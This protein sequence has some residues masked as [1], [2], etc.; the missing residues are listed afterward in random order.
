MQSRAFI[1]LLVTVLG[2]AGCATYTSL[3]LPRQAHSIA[4]MKLLT[5]PAARFKTPGIHS[6]K[7]DPSRPLD[8]DAV[9]A[10]AVLNDPALTAARA[11][12]GVAAAQSYAAGLL[13]WPKLVLGGGQ[14]RSSA[15]GLTRAWSV[16]LTQNIA[17]LLQHHDRELAA[18]ATQQQ[19]HLNLVWDEW[20]VAQRARLVYADIEMISARRAALRPLLALYAGQLKA[21]RAGVQRHDVSQSAVLRVQAAMTAIVATQ[22]KL[23]VKYAKDMASL[24]GLLGLAPGVPLSLALRDHPLPPNAKTVR[25]AIKA[26]PSRRPDLMALAAAY[27]SAN[28]RLRQAVLAQFPLIGI[29]VRHKRDTEGVISDGLSVTFKLP[30]L[31]NARGAVAKARASR[32]ALNA[33]YAARLNDAVTEALSLRAQGQ[34]IGQ[35]LATLRSSM[36][37]LP[38]APEETALGNVSFARLAAYSRERAQIAST[39]AGL[40]HSLDETSIALETLL[41]MPI[42]SRSAGTRESA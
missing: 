24:H 32:L 3:P 30:F 31:N 35:A 10:L 40:Q 12:L 37:R 38:A 22:D 2:L 25:A 7:V 21:A 41:G 29:A 19:V 9:A 13:P 20:Q 4:R 26:L 27:R 33:A 36:A 1:L 14:P 6:I 15:P 11:R 5:M 39:I 28:Q 42:D 8:A 18:R 17:A 16:A 34:H 23:D